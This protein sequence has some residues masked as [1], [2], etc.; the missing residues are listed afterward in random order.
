MVCKPSSESFWIRNECHEG[1]LAIISDRRV[2]TVNTAINEHD[3]TGKIS[4]YS[5]SQIFVQK[6]N[7]TSFSPKTF[8]TIFLVKSR[9]SIAKK[10]KTAAFSRV[11]T[12][13]ISTFFLG[14]SKLNFWTKNEDCKQCA[15][16][17]FFCL[18][19]IQFFE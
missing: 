3:S 5:K 6:F 2:V 14:K 19:F 17:A 10:S 8:L 16:V 9:L 13:N 12:Q 18:Y 11:F 1:F 7:L 15:W 4:H